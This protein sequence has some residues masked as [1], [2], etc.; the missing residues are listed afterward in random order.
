M[1]NDSDATERWQSSHQR[2]G[3][4]GA[5]FGMRG[6]KLSKQW[7]ASVNTTQSKTKWSSAQAGPRVFRP[8]A[9]IHPVHA[10]CFWHKKS[11][12]TMIIDPFGRHS[13]AY[14]CLY[15]IILF[16][17]LLFFF[18]FFFL[19]KLQL[20]TESYIIVFNSFYFFFRMVQIFQVRNCA[21]D[22]YN[23][24]TFI[25]FKHTFSRK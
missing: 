15:V 18:F 24:N 4:N 10:A 2:R 21:A 13:V 9:N 3:D 22:I 20:P 1:F 5:L 11:V 6:M 17:F 19:K 16:F 23:S 14:I 7:Y 25:H 12:I 8:W